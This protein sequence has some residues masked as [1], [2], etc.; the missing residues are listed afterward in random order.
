LLF[1]SLFVQSEQNCKPVET[2]AEST[3]RSCDPRG[4]RESL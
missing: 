4:A 1:C 3:P 2:S